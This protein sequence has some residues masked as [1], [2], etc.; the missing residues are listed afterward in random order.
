MKITPRALTALL[1]LCVLV[2]ST[3][4]ADVTVNV[5]DASTH[6]PLSGA[7]VTVGSGKS[8][9]DFYTGDDGAIKVPVAT[10]KTLILQVSSD[11]F[12]PLY[13]YY[14]PRGP[15]DAMPDHFDFS[16]EHAI[17]ISGTVVDQDNNP[18]SG[19]KV[20]INVQKKYP[21]PDVYLGTSWTNAT[22][23]AMGNWSYNGIPETFDSINMGAYHRDCIGD[24][25]YIPLNPFKDV[26]ALKNGTASFKLTR[27]NPV[28]ITVTDENGS[29]VRNA[30]ITYGEDH[31]SSNAIPT[32]KTNSKGTCTLGIKAG[33]TAPLTIM[34]KGYSPEFQRVVIGSP[35]QALNIKLSAGHILEGTVVDS[36][37]DPVAKAS[38]YVES[39]RGVR[40][41]NKRLS[42]DVDGHFSWTEAPA[43]EVKVNVQAPHGQSRDVSMK[44]GDENKVTLTPPTTFKGTVVDAATN[45]PIDKYSVALGITWQLNDAIQNWDY[46]DQNREVHPSGSIFDIEFSTTYPGRSIRVTAD[47]YLPTDSPI[48]PA[49]T[50]KP[51][52]SPS[53]WKRANP[54]PEKSS[55]PMAL[56]SPTPRSPS[57]PPAAT[58]SSRTAKSPTTL[59]ATPS[60][61]EPLP[62][63][64]SLS[65]PSVMTTSSLPLPPSATPRLTATPSTKITPSPSSPGA[66]LRASPCTERNPPPA[67]PSMATPSSDSPARPRPKSRPNNENPRI[68]DSISATTDDQG[69]FTIEHV[70]PG[71]ISVGIRVPMSNNSWTTT[72]SE[73]LTVEAGKTATVQVGGKGRTITGRIVLPADVE[74]QPHTF[75]YA[76]IQ[77]DSQV[78]GRLGALPKEFY[79]LPKD[80]RADWRKKYE[81]S[82]A[83]KKALEEQ[84]KAATHSHNFNIP[85][86]ADGS[87]SAEGILEGNYRLNAYI[88]GPSGGK[89]LAYVNTKFT[90]PPIPGGVSDDPLDIGTI[91]ATTANARGGASAPGQP[92]ITTL[93]GQPV[94]I[95]T[96]QKKH[97]LIYVFSP[98]NPASD[99]LNEKIKP[100][101]DAFGK[102]ENFTIL[103]L[104]FNADNAAAKAYVADHHIPWTVATI[105]D[106]NADIFLAEF[107]GHDFPSAGLVNPQQGVNFYIAP[108]K[109]LTTVQSAL[110]AQPTPAAPASTTTTAPA[111]AKK[112]SKPATT[113]DPNDKLP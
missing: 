83:G 92:Q 12:A 78:Q 109:L 76:F 60:P 24:D 18:L 56:P 93:D 74:A 112:T 89:Q 99:A 52:N 22:T 63:A 54:S 7:K 82:D 97:V 50:A 38:V 95:E 87:F 46:A 113:I 32:E 14:I 79:L 105:D 84:K 58:S 85:V 53:K 64:P 67:S 33:N 21:T 88:S 96:F 70:V 23:D 69:K 29:P 98:N 91:P 3:R 6:K 94:D 48:F 34:A 1:S 27:G 100:I 49:W 106:K 35:P 101:Y 9:Q 30:T 65:P 110:S 11:G 51:S 20:F 75:Q 71:E 47:G 77:D 31:N 8:K 86:K 72:N 62:T 66:A 108:D 5:T 19:A 28:T 2:A 111:K 43:D 104:V 41:V 55:M 80:Q 61:P 25:T 102:N 103:G 44:A 42:T 39:W 26:A 37:G 45:Q 17:T 36:N 90:M 13:Q 4:A 59:S 81:A 68:N 40:T 57:S 16:L 10:P 107:A 73:S 15:S